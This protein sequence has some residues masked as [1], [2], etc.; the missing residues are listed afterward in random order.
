M[1]QEKVEWFSLRLLCNEQ[2]IQFENKVLVDGR[3]NIRT[4]V[5]VTHKKEGRAQG[6]HVR[7]D[8]QSGQHTEKKVGSYNEM[9]IIQEEVGK[10]KSRD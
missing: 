9:G 1:H 5:Y 3:G 2:F 6:T 4:K 8:G 7:N 10:N